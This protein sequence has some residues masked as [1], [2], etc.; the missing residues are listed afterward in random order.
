MNRPDDQ[1]SGAARTPD[2]KTL[3]FASWNQGKLGEIQ[4]LLADL[5]IACRSLADCPALTEIVEDGDSF[6]ANATKK[7]RDT[8]AQL[9]ETV[10]ADDSGL[11]VDALGGAPGIYS[12][13]YAGP[14]ADDNKNIAKLL[15]EMKGIPAGKR[16]AAFRCALVL[17]DPDGTYV[18]FEG[19]WPGEI[20][21]EA[22]GDNGFGYDPVFYLADRGMTA[23]QLPAEVKN[24]LSHRAQA[25]EQLKLYLMR[26]AVSHGA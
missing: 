13:R 4:V 25:I 26:N 15:S 17:C 20:A 23:A 11:E 24:R 22:Q 6:L 16:S 12:A 7:A 10:L 3:V 19:S 8:A 5:G 1:A 18:A 9:G 14:N 21:M 2:L